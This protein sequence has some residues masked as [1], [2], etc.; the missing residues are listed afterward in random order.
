MVYLVG[1]VYLVGDGQWCTLSC[2]VVLIYAPPRGCM[3]LV[4]HAD[5][6]LVTGGGLLSGLR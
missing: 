4:L 5:A 1:L 6:G 2:V 3:R